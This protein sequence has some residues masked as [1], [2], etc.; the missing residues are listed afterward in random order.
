ME[1]GLSSR[2][3]VEVLARAAGE[4]RAVLT[5]NCGDFAALHAANP[6]HGGIIGIYQ[7]EEPAKNM[8]YGQVVEALAHFSASGLDI[9]GQFVVLNTWR[10]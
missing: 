4:G 5:R 1:A 7:D 2:T 8:T 3:D 6:V 10:W 9:G